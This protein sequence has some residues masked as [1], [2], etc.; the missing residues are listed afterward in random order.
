MAAAGAPA[1]ALPCDTSACP[2]RSPISMSARP[3]AD[4]NCAIHCPF[5]ISHVGRSPVGAYS[6]TSTREV[7]R[8]GSIWPR[9]AMIFGTRV[10]RIV[11]SRE[12]A[13]L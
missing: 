5:G 7:R 2:A 9:A 1:G 12:R 3:M 6:T 13:S 4:S 10:R 11:A 8:C